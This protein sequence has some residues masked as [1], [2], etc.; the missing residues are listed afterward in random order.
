MFRLGVAHAIKEITERLDRIAADRTRFGLVVKT[1][2]RRRSTKERRETHSFVNPSE[3]IG[4]EVDQRKI[5]SL[6]TEADDAHDGH[7]EIENRELVVI[8]IHGIAG[9][10]KT[11]LTRLV[12]NDEKVRDY[13]ELRMWVHVSEDFDVRTLIKEIHGAA[14]GEINNNLSHDQVL[15]RLRDK[16]EGKRFLLVLDDVWND[17][18]NRWLELKG[19][20]TGGSE[21]SKI[22]VTTRSEKVAKCMGT[23]SSYNL[24]CLSSEDSWALFLKCAFKDGHD[25]PNQSLVEIGQQILLNK[26]KGI[27]LAVRTLGSLLYW[28]LDAKYW[29]YI[30]ENKIW[31]PKEPYK[32]DIFAALLVSYCDLPTHLKR[33]F[34][35]CSLF[36]KGKVIL[37]LALIQLWMAHGV[38][39]PEPNEYRSLE[40]IGHQYFEE[41]CSRS[42]FQYVKKQGWYYSFFMH[43]LVHDFVQFVARSECKMIDISPEGDICRTVRHLSINQLSD[44]KFPTC[45][46]KLISV[47]T[48]LFP[49]LRTE[50]SCNAFFSKYLRKYEY[51]RMLDLSYSSFETLPSYIGR[52]KQ[53][54]NINLSHNRKIT[55]LP[56]SITKLQSLLTLQLQGCSKLEK[57]P[58]KVRNLSSLVFLSITTTEM[59]FP[60]NGIGCLTS[61]RTLMIVSC[62]RLTYLSDEIM[63]SLTALETLVISYC[64]NLALFEDSDEKVGRLSL[65]NLIFMDLPWM[66]ALPRWLQ[67]CQNTL[68]YL[69][70][71]SCPN[72]TALPFWLPQTASLHQIEIGACPK[73]CSLPEGMHCFSSQLELRIAQCPKLKEYLISSGKNW[74]LTLHFAD[75]HEQQS[76]VR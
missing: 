25:K 51:L 73:L 54:R 56:D 9:L 15:T 30:G 46:D 61:L 41:L 53:L 3:V 48:I 6:L 71:G 43:D 50:P 26:C 66:E 67:G 60:T 2:E 70:L 21:G 65:R 39:V 13:F 24:E 17:D 72:L 59:C 28:N 63:R 40:E 74:S 68:Q 18:R 62:K 42:F 19:L 29:R 8:P 23:V 35:Y 55:K 52:M 33:C 47:R 34:L 44:D 58:R 64:K 49:Y 4:R 14:T 31:E 57:L 36:P 5:I 69:C 32:N 37:S 27:P 7:D 12:Y 1:E 11:A 38:L 10:G 16:L 20:L 76:Q 75:C 45:L 22:I